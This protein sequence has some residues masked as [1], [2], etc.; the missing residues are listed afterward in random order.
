MFDSLDVVQ[1]HYMQKKGL[2]RQL[3]GFWLNGCAHPVFHQS[4]CRSKDFHFRRIQM[5]FSSC[6]HH[7]HYRRRP[8]GEY[9]T[10]SVIYCDSF[11]FCLFWPK[12]AIR[13]KRLSLCAPRCN[14][15][16]EDKEREP[17]RK[18]KTKD[19]DMPGVSHL[20]CYMQR[21]VWNVSKWTYYQVLKKW[22]DIRKYQ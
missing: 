17:E 4:V 5:M 15:S 7:M 21:S 14:I 6:H 12:D 8:C 9:K 19:Y 18:M 13:T 16:T 1:L 11:L 2:C 20:H 3:D 22:K 10:A